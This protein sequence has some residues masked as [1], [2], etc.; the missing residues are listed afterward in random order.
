VGYQELIIIFLIILL[1][2]G[3]RKIPE[4]A[5]GL[6]KGMREFRKARDGIRDAIDKETNDDKSKEAEA[7]DAEDEEGQ[8]EQDRRD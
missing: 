5:R 1:L 8:E 2:F 3:G 7:G 6:G 4:I